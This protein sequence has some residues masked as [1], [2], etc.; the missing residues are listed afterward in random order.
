MIDEVHHTRAQRRRALKVKPTAA[1]VALAAVVSVAAIALASI[2]P[3]IDSASNASLGERILVTAQG[4]T[5]YA[6]SPETSGHLLCK[7][8]ECLKLWPPLTVSLSGEKAKLSGGVHGR[9]GILRRAGGMLQVTLN[10]HPLYRYAQDAAGGEVNGQNLHSFGGTWHVLSPAGAPSAKQPS[11]G[12][13]SGTTGEPAGGGSTTTT[14]TTSTPSAPAPSGGS[15]GGG[16]GG[17]GGGY[18]Y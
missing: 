16:G 11:H 1:A 4:R 15:G 2:S 14:P 10:G 7:S 18:Q 6:L 8:H 3:N 13:Q 17:Y 5:L 12:A 9:L